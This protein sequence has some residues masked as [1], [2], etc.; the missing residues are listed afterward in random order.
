MHKLI[1]FLF[2]TIC[3]VGSLS[4]Q[5]GQLTEEAREKIAIA[6]DTLSVFAYT[7]LHDSLETNRYA[8]CREMIPLLVKTLK[9]ENSFRYPFERLSSISIQ[10][11]ADSSFRIF[12]WQL[13]ISKDEYKYYG[14][15]Q[16]NSPDLKLYPLIDRSAAIS[17]VELEGR[18]M[19]HDNW[20]GNVVYDIQSVEHKTGDYYLLF[21]MDTYESYRRR[22]LIDVLSFNEVSGKPS[23]G[24][25]VFVEEATYEGGY[26]T[27]RMRLVQE[28]S[29]ASYATLKYDPELELIMQENLITVSGSYGEGPVN[30]PD[31]SYV[32]YELGK[33]GRWHSVK[34][35]YNHVYDEAPRTPRADDDGNKRDLLGRR[36][37]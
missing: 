21:G 32:G 33:D 23:F 22:K 36:K 35:V 8:A 19:P 9:N 12:T 20:Y 37:H 3:T 14:A 16:M 10:Y 27:V 31:G 17:P 6:E 24:K 28:Y 15:I 11:P 29:A 18:E 26:P 5:S 4:S 13:F 1:Q 7:V 30:V 2:I 34:K 25:P